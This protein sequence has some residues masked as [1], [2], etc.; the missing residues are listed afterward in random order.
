MALVLSQVL[1]ILQLFFL[2]QRQTISMNEEKNKEE[3]NEKLSWSDQL[4]A[5]C[6]TDFKSSVLRR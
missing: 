1:Y 4:E 5:K 6:S 3:K 2:Q